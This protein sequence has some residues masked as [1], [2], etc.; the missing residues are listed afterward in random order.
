MEEA[1]VEG[2]TIGTRLCME[3][4][5]LKWPRVDRNHGVG[6]NGR[7]YDRNEVEER[8]KC[9]SGRTTRSWKRQ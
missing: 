2:A 9:K 7:R 1:G 3:G 4:E 8:I 5:R 6:R